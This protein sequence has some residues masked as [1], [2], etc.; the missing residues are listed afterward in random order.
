MHTWLAR[1]ATKGSRFDRALWWVDD[2][3]P[4]VYVGGAVLLAALL[5]GVAKLAEALA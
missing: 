3:E 4:E 1:F 2:H 5:V